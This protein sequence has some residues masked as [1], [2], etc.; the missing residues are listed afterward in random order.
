MK[1]S[2]SSVKLTTKGA[3]VEYATSTTPDNGQVFHRNLKANIHA[4]LHND[5]AEALNSVKAIFV[6]YHGFKAAES[7]GIKMTGI[8]MSGKVIDDSDMRTVVLKASKVAKND[9]TVGMVTGRIILDSDV[10]GFEAELSKKLDVIIN[11]ADLYVGGKSAQYSIPV[12]A[13]GEK[14]PVDEEKPKK[15]KI[16]IKIDKGSISASA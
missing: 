4:P 14:S 15:K 5:F 7:D 6:D 13:Q 16:V 8:T 10:F 3:V 2:I 12:E 1:I 11:E 9:S